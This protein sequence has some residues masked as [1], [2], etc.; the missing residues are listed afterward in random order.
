MEK[1]NTVSSQRSSEKQ[2]WGG[3]RRFTMTLEDEREFLAVW[4]S[5]A[6]SGALHSVFPIHT[7]LEERL[8]HEV[9][10]STT[11]RI[12]ERHGWKKI[13]P[14]HKRLQKVSGGRGQ[15]KRRALKLWMP[16]EDK[17]KKSGCFPVITQSHS[18]KEEIPA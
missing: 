14:K 12:L 10:L 16:P 3:R 2:S 8:G 1:E 9:I 17:N 15:L 4:E 7:A 5:K 18:T 11:Y 13:Y 6:L